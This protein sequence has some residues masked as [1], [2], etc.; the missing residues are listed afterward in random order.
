MSGKREAIENA[1]GKFYATR[2]SDGTFKKMVDQHRSLSQDDRKD[3]KTTVKPG[4][5]NR[6]DG[7]RG[8]RKQ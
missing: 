7:H 2:N 1:A 8:K 5:G 6:G 3:A 4:Y